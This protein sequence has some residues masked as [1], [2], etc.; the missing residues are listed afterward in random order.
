MTILPFSAPII[1]LHGAPGTGKTTVAERM[2]SRRVLRM[3]LAD[4]VKE[5]LRI[6]FAL[7]PA[8]LW[9]PSYRRTSQ[10]LLTPQEWS[11]ARMRFNAHAYDWS[12]S[13]Q[14][15]RHLALIDWFESVEDHYYRS[16]HRQDAS[17]FTPRF[18]C[19]SL[20]EDWGCSFDPLVWVRVLGQRVHRK[21]AHNRFGPS[22]VSAVIIDDVRKVAE[23]QAI[24]QWGGAVVIL[25]P[26]ATPSMDTHP[27]EVQ[28]YSTGVEVQA[29]TTLTL[30]DPASL[31]ID[32]DWR[33]EEGH[34]TRAE[35]DERS[36]IIATIEALLSTAQGHRYAGQCEAWLRERS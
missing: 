12:A 27:S 25:R 4:P 16:G 30:R 36:A 3:S 22:P 34:T 14:V 24:R 29:N 1:G 5:F 26:Q 28:V 6:V 13:V 21:L 35:V 32:Q 8:A 10:I 31:R 2:Q 19:R 9:G 15:H 23:A 7:E 17:A 18:L 33:F 20:A 11:M